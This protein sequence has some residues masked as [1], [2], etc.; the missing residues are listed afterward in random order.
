[1]T[2]MHAQTLRALVYWVTWQRCVRAGQV[3]ICIDLNALPILDGALETIGLGIFSSLQPSNI[4][5]RRAVKNQQAA[6]LHRFYP[7]LFD[8]QTSGGLLAAVPN[9]LADT[10]ITELH[11]LGYPHTC[12]I[13]H[14]QRQSDAMES[15]YINPDESG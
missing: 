2:C 8:P 3:D 14:V 7:L 12:V 1:M 10:C 13:G 11:R 4:R 9:Q 5:L 15:I 6:A